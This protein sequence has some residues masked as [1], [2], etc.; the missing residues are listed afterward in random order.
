[1]SL[2]WRPRQAPDGT[3]FA[4]SLPEGCLDDSKYHKQQVAFLFVFNVI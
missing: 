4:Y 2:H 3:H 1:M